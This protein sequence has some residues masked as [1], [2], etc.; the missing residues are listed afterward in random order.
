VLKG[1][2][3]KRGMPIPRYLRLQAL[4]ALGLLLSQLAAP[5]P[6]LAQSSSCGPIPS[7][8]AITAGSGGSLSFSNNV[9]INGNAPSGSGVSV[10]PSGA[11]TS[12]T[13]SFPGLS[14]TSFPSFSSSTNTSGPTVAAGTYASV[15]A[16][17]SV[18]FSG[19][20]YY[21]DS[22]T[23][24]N[25]ST[26][27]FGS[28]SYFINS[29]TL[30]NNVTIT[31]SGT[32]SIYVNT[33]FTAGIGASINSPGTTSSLALYLYSN[34]SVNLNNN[35]AFQGV[36]YGPYGNNA[37]TL[38]NNAA[39]TGIIAVNGGSVSLS[40]NASITLSAADQ[41]AIGGV[42]TCGGSGGG[43]GSTASGFNVVDGYFSAYPAAS[44][45]QRI[46]TKLAGTAFTL[47]VAALNS[48][49]PTPGLMSPAYVSGANKVTVDLVDDSDGACAAS[50]AGA[51]CQAKAAVA[52]QTTSFFN[53]D[54]S[55]KSGLSFAIASAWS[56]LRARVKD[57]T[58]SHA[59]SGC[60]VDNFSVRPVS[61]AVASSANADATGAS[62]SATPAV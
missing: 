50:C 4:A 10:L 18:T 24:S 51:A 49:T 29:A 21:I 25:N 19:G 14:P 40:N 62:A 28:G 36:I 58:G 30:S 38:G 47:N 8:Y 41:T 35:V 57:T 33:S 1:I 53:S 31:V 9:E 12:A 61:L 11:R 6:V 23:A 7:T 52:T 46:F 17:G 43:A 16:S 3:R 32:V 54:A 22:L 13:P 45:G 59:T 27:A 34:A 15:S 56:N 5:V 37:V 39:F 42:S 60:S 48:A 26:L 2:D 44:A 20:T 55:Y